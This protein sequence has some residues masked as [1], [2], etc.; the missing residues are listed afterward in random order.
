LQLE[1]IQRQF[2]RHTRFLYRTLRTVGRVEGGQLHGLLVQMD[3]N[4]W[5]RLHS[6]GGGD[7]QP[8]SAAS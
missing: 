1:A 6:G 5:F 4:G 2:Q 3:F 8:P 7:E